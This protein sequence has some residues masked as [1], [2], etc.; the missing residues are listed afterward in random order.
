M[1]W[2]E[3]WREGR[4]KNRRDGKM[5]TC[6][7]GLKEERECGKGRKKESKGCRKERE[8]LTKRG[9]KVKDLY[10]YLTQQRVYM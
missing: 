9:R 1:A 8:V 7:E 5:Y 10:I 3:E 6:R 2:K 4:K